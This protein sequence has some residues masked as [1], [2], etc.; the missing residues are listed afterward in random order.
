MWGMDILGALPK[1]LGTIK[2]LL[3]S[4]NYFTK[5]IE[6]RPLWEITASEVKKFTRKHL[7]CR[8][9]LAYAIATD[10][11]TQFKAQTYKD[12]L[13]RLSI[14]SPLLNI[15]RLMDRQRQLTESSSGPCILDSI[16]LRAYG[17]KNSTT[18]SGHPTVHPE[19]QLIKPLTD[20]HMA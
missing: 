20:S 12:S 18:Y 7:I 17:K 14:K 8:Y 4:I 1:A 5:W 6:A 9:G 10:N 3:V 16:S 19:Q 2:Y 13:I 15:L 11:I